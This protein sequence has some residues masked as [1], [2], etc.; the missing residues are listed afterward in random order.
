MMTAMLRMGRFRFGGL[1][2]VVLA[3]GLL[4]GCSGGSAPPASKPEMAPAPEPT[5]VVREG[6][7]ARTRAFEFHGGIWSDLHHFLY[8]VAR[9]RLKLPDSRRDAVVHAPED[10]AKADLSPEERQSMDAAVAIYAKSFAK[11]DLVFD[12]VAARESAA[13]ARLEERETTAGED[14][15]PDLAKALELAA[16]AFRRAFWPRH[17]LSE[18]AW[19]QE[20]LPVLT[21]HSDAMVAGIENAYGV[22]WPAEPLRVDLVAYANWAGAYTVADPPRT[23]MNTTQPGYLRTGA[24][25]MLFHEA[26]HT[27]DDSIAKLLADEAQRQ[28]KAIPR[29][30]SHAIV[31]DTA[32]ELAAARVPGYVPFAEKYGLYARGP[33]FRE[34]I[35][36]IWHPHVAGRVRLADAIRDLV[37]AVGVSGTKGSTKSP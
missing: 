10:L 6:V 26:S 9:S 7:L 29:G 31:F 32:G 19:L 35:T 34:A 12:E 3:L 17:S 14:V 30:L 11:L 37:A 15:D 28:G 21:M 27:F 23:T 8:V 33:W 1:A 25:E 5:P 36:R 2:A 20:V 22:R 16:P 13:V 24:L 18:R 4:V